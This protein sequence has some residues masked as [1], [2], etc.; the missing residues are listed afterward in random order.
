MIIFEK[1]CNAHLFSS[2]QFFDRLGRRGDMDDSAGMI[3]QSFLQEAL[4]SG[5]GMYKDVHPWMY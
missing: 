5:S 4:V 2:V 1:E 3:F